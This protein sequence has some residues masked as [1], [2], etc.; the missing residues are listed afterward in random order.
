MVLVELVDLT[1]TET[2]I[3]KILEVTLEAPG[4]ET[5]PGCLWIP[6]KGTESKVSVELL[7]LI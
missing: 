6:E 4:S 1:V 5:L 2:L 7:K 3:I